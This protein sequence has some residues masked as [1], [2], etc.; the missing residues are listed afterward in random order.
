[1]ATPIL[2]TKLFIPPP[3]AELVPR[4]GLIEHLNNGLDHKLTLL[5]APAGFGKTT[6]V[7]SWVK[8]LR[9]IDENNGQ[10]IK[11]AWLSLDEEDNDHVRFLTYFINSLKQIKDIDAD[12][13]QGALSMLQSPQPPPAN[14]ILTSLINDLAVLP[15][16]II[17]VI[18]DYHLIESEAIHQAL[19]FLLEN[20]P[21][22]LHLVIA[23]RHDPHFP[24]GRLRARDQITEARAADLRFTSA[25][26]ADFLNRVMGLNLSAGDIAELENRTEGWIA[27]L[28]LAA[29]SMQGHENHTGFIKAFTGS[30]RLV[31]DYLVEDVLSQQPPNIQDFLLQTAILNR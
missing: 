27:G 7:S 22:Q 1:M 24:L 11:I 21:P 19:V 4:P 6:L 10:P 13:G 17:F 8:N 16:K 15:E 14:A 12:L 26:A 5:S 9:N 25:E 29:I 20:L 2:I 30:N 18:D 3:R 31:L 28:Q 23:T